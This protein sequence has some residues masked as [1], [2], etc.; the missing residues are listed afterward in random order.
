MH[1]GA[2]DPDLPGR[3]RGG[4]YSLQRVRDSEEDGQKPERGE[5]ERGPAGGLHQHL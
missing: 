1:P 3:L 5:G 4:G 2:D